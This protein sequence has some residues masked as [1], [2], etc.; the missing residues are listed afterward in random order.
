MGLIEKLKTR[1]R[2][3][4]KHLA[5]ATLHPRKYPP[6][7]AEIYRYMGLYLKRF[8][9]HDS[10]LICFYKA[11][12][13]FDSKYGPI[14]FQSVKCLNNM[15]DIYAER[16][17]AK[18]VDSIYNHCLYLIE[19]FKSPN[20]FA[21]IMTLY[22]MGED[23][24]E[25]GNYQQALKYV[26]KIL[27]L[28]FKGFNNEDVLSNPEN[29]T[30][31]PY[32]IV[33]LSILFKANTLLNWYHSDT[34]HQKDYNLAVYRCYELIDQ[35]L[36][37]IRKRITNLDK[38]LEYTSAISSLYYAFAY[39]AMETF[40]KTNDTT[41]VS[42]AL[43][44]ISKN[45]HLGKPQVSDIDLMLMYKIPQTAI[46]KRNELKNEIN[47][48]ENEL[49]TSKSSIL[50]DSLQQ[51][52]N[53]KM[54]ELEVYH[55]NISQ[56]YPGITSTTKPDREIYLEQ[57]LKKLGSNTTLLIFTEKCF[58]YESAPDEITVIGISEDGIK[59]HNIDGRNAW[60]KINELY[61]NISDN[62]ANKN[63]ETLTK[64]LYQLF[65]DPFNGMLKK[66]IIIIPSQ[67]VSLIPFDIL[68]DL[69]KQ[70]AKLMIETHTI[71]KEFSIHTF[72][73]ENDRKKTPAKLLAVAPAFNNKQTQ[74]L[75]ILTK[76][77]TSMINLTGAIRE[78]ENISKIYSSKL[79][80]G[81]SA[82]EENF[83]NLCPAYSI[84]HLSTH[85]IP[86]E[87]DKDMIQLAF[88]DTDND[89][90]GGFLNFYEI[91]NLQLRADLIVLSA[92][93]T[94]IGKMN[95][96]EGIVNL[97]WAFKK[98]GA[99]SAVTSLW[100][101]NDYASSQIMIKF[102]KYLHTGF[103][104]PEALRKAKL[105]YLKSNDKLMSTPY[106][107]AG[108]E[109]W[110]NETGISPDRNSWNIYLT[111][112]FLFSFIIVMVLGVRWHLHRA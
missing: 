13:L 14:N 15:A 36:T 61:K 44:Y 60:Q 43:T 80:T 53:L 78:C 27:P 48:L 104:K 83:K 5:A 82:T 19:N 6:D 71:W 106:F 93:K 89:Y 9:K 101:A 29:I 111:I 75:A 87:D 32:Y 47:L 12:E 39:N 22:N 3:L 4:K 62:A 23:Y 24:R 109:Y 90:E 81:F 112:A 65:I 96:A 46:K 88:S 25:K 40:L 92:C 18:L 26:H 58:D 73:N 55:Y 10:A 74:Q 56:T 64:D 33:Y 69:S 49:L 7:L 41:Y 50:K 20:R 110:G 31:S 38:S 35:V 17:Q 34:L 108:F 105:D 28:Y 100:D 77:D 76:R 103:S 42:K 2:R 85:G 95:K 67:H 21:Q 99:N 16:D 59:T 51:C 1:R 52:L 72:L 86:F 45:S 66:N 107:W 70:E 37:E 79:L 30:E 91:L 63:I 11:K 57:I 84:I 102:Y 68:P 94:G 97:A 8:S 54:I 98:S